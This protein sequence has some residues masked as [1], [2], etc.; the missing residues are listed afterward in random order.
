LE[1]REA[2]VKLREKGKK[3]ECSSRMAKRII[4]NS[5]EAGRGVGQAP[6][7][8]KYSQALGLAKEAHGKGR[9]FF[10]PQAQMINGDHSMGKITPM[11]ANQSS[12]KEWHAAESP[13]SQ[14]YLVSP[15]GFPLQLGRWKGKIISRI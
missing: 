9:V 7:H 2:S 5:L 1:A 11:E 15:G 6:R 12:C 3:D 8:V 13:A 4:A 14:L 10:M